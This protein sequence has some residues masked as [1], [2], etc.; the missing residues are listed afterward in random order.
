MT[1]QSPEIR[2]AF[3]VRVPVEADTAA[4]EDAINAAVDSAAERLRDRIRA[5]VEEAGQ[6]LRA[7]PTGDTQQ[8]AR[9]GEDASVSDSIAQAVRREVDRLGERV[10]EDPRQSAFDTPPSTDEEREV[11]A[12]F[13]GRV[14][15]SD[16]QQRTLEEI[17]D[18]VRTIAEL[19][20][21]G[22]GSR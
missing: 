19:L 13:V 21:Q 6:P 7:G 4:F 22:G 17:L 12:E 8:D 15:Q 18:F 2:N 9:T 11:A 14:V 16:E 10:A 20:E 3:R 5:A 1:D